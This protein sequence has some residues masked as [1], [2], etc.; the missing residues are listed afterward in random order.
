MSSRPSVL[1]RSG[2]FNPAPVFRSIVISEAL[3]VP[4][5]AASGALEPD[6]AWRLIEREAS[7]TNPAA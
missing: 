6:V 3:P 2:A 4:D 7:T 5:L 1:R